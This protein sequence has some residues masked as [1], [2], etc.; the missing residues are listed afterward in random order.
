MES[1][2]RNKGK[3]YGAVKLNQWATGSRNTQA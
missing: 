2:L 3:N 1:L